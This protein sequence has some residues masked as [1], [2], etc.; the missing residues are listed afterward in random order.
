MQVG[1]SSRSGHIERSTDDVGGIANPAMKPQTSSTTV[2]A[3]SSVKATIA[4]SADALHG[5][6]R[7]QHAAR[8]EPV[9][10]PPL[11]RRAD[12]RTRRERPRD[13][14]GDRERAG[15]LA[16]VEHDRERVDPRPAGARAAP[17][18][19]ARRRAGARKI[20]R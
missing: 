13:R 3:P 18:R 17:R 8:A 2:G 4:P 19:R 6:E 15:L 10:A 20:A 1:R 11:D 12:A 9:H 16:Q 7:E 14:A 5:G